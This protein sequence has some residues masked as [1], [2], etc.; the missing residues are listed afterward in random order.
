M[1]NTYNKELIK[2]IAI[3]FAD[4]NR[5][6][7]GFEESKEKTDFLLMFSNA[8]E[9]GKEVTQ[10]KMT[11]L[12]QT[13]KSGTQEEKG[14]IILDILDHYEITDEVKE[15]LKTE[16]ELVKS[17]RNTYCYPGAEI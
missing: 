5:T 4:G 7:E 9:L 2:Q 16:I 1:N 15:V 3:S 17:I 6:L 8:K 10:E 14:T 12:V 11:E 13:L